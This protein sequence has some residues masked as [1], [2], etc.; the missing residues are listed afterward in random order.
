MSEEEKA[1]SNEI[2]NVSDRVLDGFVNKLSSEKKYAEVA[3]RLKDV[4]FNVNLIGKS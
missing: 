4:V 2:G 3:G 1:V